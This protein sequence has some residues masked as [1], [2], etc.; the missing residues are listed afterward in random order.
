MDLKSW[1][2]T[3]GLRI[4]CFLMQ[5]LFVWRFDSSDSDLLGKPHTKRTTDGW[6][7]LLSKFK[8]S[9]VSFHS[10]D[11]PYLMKP[12][13]NATTRMLSSTFITLKTTCAPFLT[14]FSSSLCVALSL[15]ILTGEIKFSWSE[16]LFWILFCVLFYTVSD[17]NKTQTTEI[18]IVATEA[19]TTP[20]VS[21]AIMDK[22][23]RKR[24]LEALR[25]SISSSSSSEGA[26]VIMPI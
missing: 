9:T 5:F 7:A 2:L 8:R 26:A 25:L 16:M 1:W 12:Q 4:V 11:T 13:A 20:L 17:W 23:N 6:R 10:T 15:C 22:K 18:A 21:P 3:N 24:E 19:S 14:S